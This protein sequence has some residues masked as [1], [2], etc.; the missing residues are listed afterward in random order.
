MASPEGWGLE[1]DSGGPYDEF[2]AGRYGGVLGVTALA[3]I[4]PSLLKGTT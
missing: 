1:R 4:K 2:A 3:R